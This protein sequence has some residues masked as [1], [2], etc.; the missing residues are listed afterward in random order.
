LGVARIVF[1]EQDPDRFGADVR[2]RLAGEP[3]GNTGQ[4][5]LRGKSRT[6]RD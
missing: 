6:T 5:L 1:D 2:Q 4:I 3:T